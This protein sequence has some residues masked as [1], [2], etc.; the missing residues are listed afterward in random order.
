MRLIYPRCVKITIPITI[1][2][3]TRGQYIYNSINIWSGLCAI[4]GAMQARH[5]KNSSIYSTCW[6][7]TRYECAKAISSTPKTR[8]IVHAVMAF[9]PNMPNPNYQLTFPSGA[10]ATLMSSAWLIGVHVFVLVM[11]IG[12]Y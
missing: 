1:Q 9:D 8:T 3:A 2:C 5:Y 6:T 12:S 4:A 10:A 7:R 11:L